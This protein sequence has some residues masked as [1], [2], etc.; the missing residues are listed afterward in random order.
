VKKG[1]DSGGYASRSVSR[2]VSGE[3]CL[4]SDF[5]S[6]LCLLFTDLLGEEFMRG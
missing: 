5:L 2:E 6:S 3:V 1:D 4:I